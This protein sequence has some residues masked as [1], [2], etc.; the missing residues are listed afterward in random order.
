MGYGGFLVDTAA[1]ALYRAHTGNKVAP[2]LRPS[3]L[4]L[5][6][7]RLYRSSTGNAERA[8]F[9]DNPDIASLPQ[10]PS[11]ESRLDALFWKVIRKLRLERGYN[12]MLQGMCRIWARSSGIRLFYLDDERFSYASQTLEDRI[13]WKEAPHLVAAVLQGFAIAERPIAPTGQPPGRLFGLDTERREADAILSKFDLTAGNYIVIEPGT[14]TDWFGNL[15]QWPILRWRDLVVALRRRFPESQIVRIGVDA[16]DEIEGC[17]DL[18]GQTS[19]RLASA[20]IERST[21]FV[22]TEGGLMHAAR[23]VNAKAVILWGGITLPN[24]AGYPD[25]HVILIHPVECAPCG[26]LGHCPNGR[27]CIDG[28]TAQQAFEVCERALTEYTPGIVTVIS[29]VLH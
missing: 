29:K 1:F 8:I 9:R 14:N 6:R 22:G 17:V 4:D 7:G 2:V 20:L 25:R 12:A 23:A 16:I 13:I 27:K 10:H 18:R 24:F 15:R 3:L 11:A 26:L 19:F 5:C 21:L 28:I